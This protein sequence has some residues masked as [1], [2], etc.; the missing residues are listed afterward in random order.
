MKKYS[1]QKNGTGPSQIILMKF[2][3]LAE[4]K[5]STIVYLAHMN[6]KKNFHSKKDELAFLWGVYLDVLDLQKLAKKTQLQHTFPNA[7]YCSPTYIAS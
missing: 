6:W 7:Q 1:L 4:R 3:R 2:M 5:V